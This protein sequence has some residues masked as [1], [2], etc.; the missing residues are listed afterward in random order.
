MKLL[1][2]SFDAV[3]SE[4]ENA[5]TLDF[6]RN[7][8]SYTPASPYGQILRVLNKIRENIV[9]HEKKAIDGF[10]IDTSID[11]RVVRTIALVAGHDPGRNISAVGSVIVQP[12]VGVD[13]SNIA[14]GKVV[15]QDRTNMRC[16]TNGLVYS[17]NLGNTIT[18]DIYAATTI[19]LPAIEGQW[20]SQTTRGNG[21]TSQSISIAASN[22]QQPDQFNYEVLVD[23]VT[24]NKRTSLFDM[25]M[26][27]QAYYVRT[28]INGSLDIFFGT[29]YNGAIVG[30]GSLITVNWLESDGAI[31][32]LPQS[33]IDDFVFTD[34]I[35]DG[36]GNTLDIQQY[37]TLSMLDPFRFGANYEDINLTRSIIPLISTNYV[38]ALPQQFEYFVSRLGIFS[39]IRAWADNG[40]GTSSGGTVY[41]NLVPDLTTQL[42]VNGVFDYFTLDLSVF[43][44]GP[45]GKAKVYDYIRAN[46]IM[47]IGTE[48]MVIDAVLRKYAIF[49]YVRLRDGYNDQAYAQQVRD[50]YKAILS[51]TFVFLV[52]KDRITVSDLISSFASV[53]IVDSVRLVFISQ[54]NEAY[55]SNAFQNP[56]YDPTVTIGLDSDSGD[57]IY[58][59]QEVPVLRGGWYDRNGNYITD[60]PMQS[61][62]LG[63]INFTVINPTVNQPT[64]TN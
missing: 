10:D 62:E 14:G 21:E 52:R 20:R 27:E 53:S 22:N 12:I 37:F 31:G 35:I 42:G 34:E 2:S 46:A 57:I 49:I 16:S 25:I 6:S 29:H 51:D 55:Q 9:L 59:P 11:P 45:T 47:H 1:K 43:L 60:G 13:L 61:G 15:F 7:G 5:L 36:L 50:T 44:L 64:T 63:P 30:I 54:R 8:E 38:L 3:Q 28:G 58:G 32:N 18:W 26:D 23:G 33:P 40:S 56:N 17:L 24:W 39:H 48:I 19:T 41:L 4:I